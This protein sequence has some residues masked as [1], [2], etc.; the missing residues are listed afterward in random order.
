MIQN[1]RYVWE[2]LALTLGLLIVWNYWMPLIASTSPFTYSLGSGDFAL[3]YRAAGLWL[4]NQN[5][6][7]L[8]GATTNF[9]YPPS[10]LPLYGLFALMDFRPASE[11]WALS[12]LLVF[13]VACSLLGYTLEADRKRIYVLAAILMF[14]TSYPVLYLIE[15]GQCDLLVAGVAI[16]GLAFHR[17]GHRSVSAFSL[18]IATLL[19]GPAVLFLIYFAVFQRDVRYLAYFL[20]STTSLV[21][22]SLLVVSVGLY[23]Y[24]LT[25]VL[26][27][28][29]TGASSG[30]FQVTMNG[31]QSIPTLFTLAGFS[32]ITPVVSI[33]GF[34]VFGIFSFWVGSR[35]SEP[36]VRGA[37]FG[38]GMFLMN[39][40]MM[41]LF[42]PRTESYSYVWV[43]LPL[44]L[45]LSA[46]V[47]EK[48]NPL[49]L[50]LICFSI[51]MFNCF[52]S[53]KLFGL[54]SLPIVQ[55][56]FETV[57]SL[58]LTFALVVMYLKPTLAFDAL[59]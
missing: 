50:V 11:M 53:L 14:I 37:I 9:V 46:L 45:L 13:I 27:M 5:P 4:A 58:I 38:D 41:L 32:Y 42:I 47:V 18:S 21:V 7:M 59:D 2:I 54:Q 16:L 51:F 20:V 43:I 6:Y 15:L 24:Y 30:R 57:G 55:G 39:V 29:S 52:N 3:F 17:M 1:E 48:P 40:L 33:L 31:A 34:I 12:Y 25:K 23:S 8:N 44:A 10:S 36:V 56:P 28:L 22:A 19:K 35:T 49:F 26:P